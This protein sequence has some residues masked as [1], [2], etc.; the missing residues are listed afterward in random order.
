MYFRTSDKMK[1]N[2]TRK[3]LFTC[4]SR[5]L[6]N[7]P[8]TQAALQQHIQH[9]YAN[10]TKTGTALVQDLEAFNQCESGWTY[11]LI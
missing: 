5:P 10:R 6:E 1:E 8:L 9:A 2:T 4:I 11:K 7:I 3:E